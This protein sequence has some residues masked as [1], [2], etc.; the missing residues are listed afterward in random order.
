MFDQKAIQELKFYV[1]GLIDPETNKPFYIGKG[2]KNRVF[3]HVDEAL[4]NP[5]QDDKL[6]KIREIKSKGFEVKHIIFRHG[7]SENESFQIESV[8][9][10]TIEYFQINL[11]NKV[12]GHHSI[13]KGLMTTNEVIRLYKSEPLNEIRNDAGIININRLYKRGTGYEGIYNAVRECWPLKEYRRKTLKYILAEYKGL[14]VEVFEVKGEWY[15]VDDIY[16]SGKRKGQK[17]IRWG[18]VGE[19]ATETIRELYLNKSI[20]HHKKRG[21][22]NPLRFNL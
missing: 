1:Y 18:F 20:S 15:P 2:E 8:L 4:T 21:A 5:S 12:K 16:K 13:D 3:N 19:K 14:I 22:S 10:D 7:L 6:D 17:R 11:T 9:I